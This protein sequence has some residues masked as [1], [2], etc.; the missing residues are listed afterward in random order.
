MKNS[1]LPTPQLPK[2]Q[3]RARSVARRLGVGLFGSWVLISAVGAAPE[4]Q[5]QQPAP[6][7]RSGTKL[8]V[9]SVTVR[10]RQGNAVEGLTAADFTI[11]EDGVPQQ[12]SFVDFQSVP[13]GPA[14][15]PAQIAA[16]AGPELPAAPPTP[17]VLP[18]ASVRITAGPAGTI[19]YRDRRLMVLYFDLTALPPA[20]QSRSY[21]AALKYIATQMQPI[22][23]VSVMSFK[24][25]GVRVWTDFTDNRA[26]LTE[27]I[28]TLVFGE[29]KDNDGVADPEPGG[30]FGQDG[31]EFGLFNTDRQLAALQTAI[32]MLR[33]L[34][35]QKN[36]VFFASNLRMNGTDNMAQMRATVNAALRANVAI[37]PIDARGLVASAPLGDATQ[38]SPGGAGMFSGQLAMAAINNAQRSQDTMFSLAKDTGGKAMFD[39]NDLSVGIV[40]AA[41]S[42][43]SY[44]IIG[45]YTTHTANDGKFHR[46][47][48]TLNGGK[49]GELSYRQ[50]YYADKEFAK[51]NNADKERQLEEA[52]MLENPIT[53][54]TIAMEL[55]YFQLNRAEYFIPVAVKI[56][57]SELALARAGGAQRTVIDFIGEVKDD[58]NSTIQN[59]RDK[60]E[61]RISDQTAAELSKRPVQIEFGFTVL[62]GKYQIKILARDAETGRIGTYHANFTVPNLMREDKRLPISSVVLGS[63]RVPMTDALFSA[64][65]AAVQNANPLVYEGQKLM[66]SVTRVFSRSRDLF[67]YLQA[68]QRYTETMQPLAAFVTFYRDGVK[69][70]ETQ[71]LAVVDG[72]DA[73]SRAIPLRF[74]IP[75]ESLPA[76]RYDVQVTVLEPKGQ[77]V[78]FWQAP[79]AIVP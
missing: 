74:S 76:G 32:E 54:I 27:I 77:R 1:Q 30:A 43:T 3:F 78:A 72:M 48:V 6:I 5:Q 18:S 20:E 16:A 39:Y 79:I 35:E 62:P 11:T 73:R 60:L 51:F 55:N 53:D 29:D 63:Q 33:P 52:L 61:I 47:R 15:D 36:L 41:Q 46:V 22:D 8:V 64:R 14:A 68:Y 7:F 31:G 70:F 12:I 65:N 24:G 75:L 26:A 21:N 56:P 17:A 4:A 66:P 13:A 9:Q 71:P 69:A 58:F 67:V 25:S 38:R 37:S 59:L 34:P 40:Q 19:K 28:Y 45:Y 57:G 44:Y 10:D 2:T 49:E 42:L 23:L 50:G